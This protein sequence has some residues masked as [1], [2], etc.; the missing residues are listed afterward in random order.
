MSKF[1]VAAGSENLGRYK[2]A[3]C[4]DLTFSY[5][6]ICAALLVV[7]TPISPRKR[8][9]VNSTS[10]VLPLSCQARP[11]RFLGVLLSLL[12]APSTLRHPFSSTQLTANA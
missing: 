1:L 10:T 2:Y 12:T 8:S 7:A 6:L 3:P 9:V 4:R 11:A 5:T